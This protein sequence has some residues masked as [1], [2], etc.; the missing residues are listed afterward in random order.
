MAQ[1]TA[2]Q[3]DTVRMALS[4]LRDARSYILDPAHHIIRESNITAFP[5]HTWT[6]GTGRRAISMNKEIGSKLVGLYHAIDLLEHMLQPEQT[7]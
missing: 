4:S 6:N 3:K 1:L 7:Q 2:K 5:E